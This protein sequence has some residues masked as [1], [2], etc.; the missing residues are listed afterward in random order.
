M[1]HEG[2]VSNGGGG[3]SNG[4][5]PTPVPTHLFVVNLQVVVG[6]LGDKAGSVKQYRRKA[7]L[8]ARRQLK[9]NNVFPDLWEDAPQY[10]S[11]RKCELLRNLIPDAVMH[12]DTQ[13]CK[14][15]WKTCGKKVP[16]RT[17]IRALRLQILE[18]RKYLL[19][20]PGSKLTISKGLTPHC[21]NT[22]HTD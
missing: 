19:D 10:L 16:A 8:L 15:W 3:V 9:L 18:W 14:R 22:T 11:P 13:W 12:E 5:T 4:R 6:P 20:N 2:G 21:Y 1:D 7:D 17:P